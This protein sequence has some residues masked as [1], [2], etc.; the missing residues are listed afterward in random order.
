MVSIVG[1]ASS[2]PIMNESLT[3]KSLVDLAGADIIKFGMESKKSSKETSTH[4]FRLAI[5]EAMRE[6]RRICEKGRPEDK[7]K[8]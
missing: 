5:V 3:F 8:L 7:S 6:M 4:K 2:H 1:C